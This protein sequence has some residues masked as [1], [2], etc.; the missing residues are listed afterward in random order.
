MIEFGVNL[1][2]NGLLITQP[3]PSMPSFSNIF[4]TLKKV[5]NFFLR[6]HRGYF[7]I[8]CP[9]YFLKPL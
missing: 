3:H 1:G 5:V 9:I 8:E 2:V 6:G 4:T 7:F